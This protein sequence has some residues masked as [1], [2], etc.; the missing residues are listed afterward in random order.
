MPKEATSFTHF[1]VTP[2]KHMVYA[3]TW[4][5]PHGLVGAAVARLLCCGVAYIHTLCVIATGLVWHWLG[6]S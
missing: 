1:Y 5:V 6:R 4:C 3:V 2:A